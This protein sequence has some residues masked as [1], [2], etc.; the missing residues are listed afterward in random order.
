MWRALLPRRLA[1]LALA[2]GA[3]VAVSWWWAGPVPPAGYRAGEPAANLAAHFASAHG[4]VADPLELRVVDAGSAMVG[5]SVVV[6]FT[7]GE[8]ADLYTARARLSAAGIPI[9]VGAPRNVSETADGHEL[10]LDADAR[11]VLYAVQVDGRVASVAALDFGESA[12]GEGAGS[13]RGGRRRSMAGS[14]SAWA[15]CRGGSTCGW[16]RRRRW[17]SAGSR[18]RRRC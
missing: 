17:S 3:A 6:W 16:S 1:L 2:V 8:P 12:L 10:L 11:R 7:A 18:A 15:C 13:R 14:A 9:A 5:R 4:L